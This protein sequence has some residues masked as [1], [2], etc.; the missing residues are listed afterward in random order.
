MHFFV[1]CNIIELNSIH[2]LN[3]AHLLLPFLRGT[4][5]GHQRCQPESLHKTFSA[6]INRGGFFCEFLN[7]RWFTKVLCGPSKTIYFQ[8]LENVLVESEKKL[9]C[10]PSSLR[11]DLKANLSIKNILVRR[12]KPLNQVIIDENSSHLNLID[13]KLNCPLSL[14]LSWW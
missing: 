2:V 5:S 13:G 3:L 11:L 1:K 8:P 7:G 12:D 6:N 4:D 10:L 14:P 9:D